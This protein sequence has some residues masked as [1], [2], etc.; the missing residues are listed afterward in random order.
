MDDY[1]RHYFAD[2][3]FQPRKS[4]LQAAGVID[5]IIAQPED[6][7]GLVSFRFPR[8]TGDQHM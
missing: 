2:S 8:N 1:C 5:S 4:V 7:W 3:G 6:Q